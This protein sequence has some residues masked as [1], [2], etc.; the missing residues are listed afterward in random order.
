[1][2]MKFRK[3]RCSEVLFRNGKPSNTYTTFVDE[4]P[5]GRLIK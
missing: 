4:L 1:M 3:L 5:F 2:V